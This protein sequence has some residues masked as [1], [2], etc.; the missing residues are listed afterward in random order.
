MESSEPHDPTVSPIK[1]GL[2]AIQRPA[3]YFLPLA[4]GLLCLRNVRRLVEAAMFHL[5]KD[6]QAFGGT[7]CKVA[8]Q[9]HWLLSGLDV[10]VKDGTQLCCIICGVWSLLRLKE[11]VIKRMVDANRELTATPSHTRQQERA[12]ERVVL[13]LSGLSSWLVVLAGGIMAL[14]VLGINVQPLLTV[15]GV[16]GLI[17]GLSAQSVMANMISGINLFLSRPFVV[18]DRIDVSTGSGQKFLTG[19]VERV[20]P[21]RTIIRSDV[22]LPFMLP[23]KVLADMIITNESRVTKSKMIAAYNLPRQYLTTLSVRLQDAD[24]LPGIIRDMRE[25][26]EGDA[27]VDKRLPCFV[28]LSGFEDAAC[29]IIL[30]V[31]T[32]PRATRDWGNF[33]QSILFRMHTIITNRGASLTYPTQVNNIQLSQPGVEAIAAAAHANGSNGS[34]SSEKRNGSEPPELV[35]QTSEGV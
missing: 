31:Y 23:N 15:T 18:G 9:A 35:L 21:M 7:A 34:N 8:R 13:P 30:L 14:Q 11:L 3:K 26:L 22:G 4:A 12:L 5:H 29:N 1:I 20:D 16:S 33:R 28:G 24:K 19:Y 25:V 27:G 6:P 2:M 10:L 32:T 17:V